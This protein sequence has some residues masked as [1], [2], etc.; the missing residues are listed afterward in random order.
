MNEKQLEELIQLLE[1]EQNLQAV[2]KIEKA[3][4]KSQKEVEE[5]KKVEVQ[6]SKPII[7]S[8]GEATTCSTCLIDTAKIIED[9]AKDVNKCDLQNTKTIDVS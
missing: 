6:E 4:A 8:P 2:G 5:A 7:R 9:H 3:L 1:K